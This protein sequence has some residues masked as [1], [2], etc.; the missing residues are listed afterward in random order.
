MDLAALT[1]ET[2]K[3]L[4]GTTFVVELP[5]GKDMR[6]QLEEVL[7]YE[8]RAR[9][10]GA[11]PKRSPFSLYFVGPLDPVLPQAMYTLRS[12]HVTFDKLFIV[13][14]GQHDEGTD[15]EAVFN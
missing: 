15:Y 1:Y 4:E 10:R 14:V 5:D 6:I 9:R 3:E 8:T 7:P 11:P 12:E 2:A 13:P